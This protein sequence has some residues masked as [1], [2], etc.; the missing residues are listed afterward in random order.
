M[1]E[2]RRAVSMIAADLES[3]VLTPPRKKAAVGLERFRAK[4]VP[5]RVKKTRQDKNP[6]LRF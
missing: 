5:V 1:K 4:R 6:D 3:V 2:E